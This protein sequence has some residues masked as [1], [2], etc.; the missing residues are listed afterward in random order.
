MREFHEETQLDCPSEL[1]TDQ[2]AIDK[3]YVVFVVQVAEKPDISHFKPNDKQL[4]LQ[5][6]NMAFDKSKCHFLLQV[7]LD[8]VPKYI[9]SMSV[10]FIPSGCDECSVSSIKG[11]KRSKGE[12][13]LPIGK[14]G[15]IEQASTVY[16]LHSK[17]E[18]I[19]QYDGVMVDLMLNLTQSKHA[20][21]PEWL[22]KGRIFIESSCN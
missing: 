17:D 6:I 21:I 19:E 1:L 4:D 5:W 2:I 16:P 10:P 9:F 8:K 11:P 14:F 22:T 12:K 18:Y 7:A 20:K 13:D 15:R 3:Y